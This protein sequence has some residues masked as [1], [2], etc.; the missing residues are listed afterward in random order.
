MRLIK[1]YTG[2]FSVV[3][4]IKPP[5]VIGKFGITANVAPA[6]GYLALVVMFGGKFQ[7]S[8]ELSLN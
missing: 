5:G 8:C 1:I 4:A 6:P 3:M 2:R 7:W